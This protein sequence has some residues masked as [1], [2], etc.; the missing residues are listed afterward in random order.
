MRHRFTPASVL[1]HPLRIGMTR[2][3]DNR[4]FHLQVA[5]RACVSTIKRSPTDNHPTIFDSIIPFPLFPNKFYLCDNNLDCM[6]GI[7][8]LQSVAEDIVR[9]YGDDLSSLI[10]VFPNNRAQLF[11]NDCL[12]NAASDLGL[13]HPIW[14][15]SYTTIKKMFRI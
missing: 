12:L 1:W 10:V 7:P 9:K 6:F 15:P 11:F 4:A 5:C 8:F 13:K 3:S 2:E 14:S